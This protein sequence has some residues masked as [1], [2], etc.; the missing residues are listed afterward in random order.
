MPDIRVLATG[1]EFP[2]GPVAMPDG[3]VLLVEIRGQRLTRVWPDGRKEVV[4]K[5]PG[6]PNGAAIGP[7]G[8][9]Y[10]CEYSG[11]RIRKAREFLGLSQD[12]LARLADVS[13]GAVS[14][15]EAGRGMATPLL[16]FVKLNRVMPNVEPAWRAVVVGPMSR[17][18]QPGAGCAAA[19]VS[20][21]EALAR[22][23]G[24]GTKASEA[25]DRRAGARRQH[26]ARRPA[27]AGPP[28]RALRRRRQRP[29]ARGLRGPRGRQA[30]AAHGF[31]VRRGRERRHRYH[32][33]HHP[34]R[35]QRQPAG[36]GAGART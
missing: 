4:A 31:R 22:D 5:I 6:G 19:V 17:S 21:G 12:Q 9:L 26:R 29:H 27:R 20:A 35:R 18:H 16:T 33:R 34:D 8:A 28:A 25:R 32:R 24:A 36:A 3:S 13:Q 11:Q 10:F 2:E 7:D 23:R 14:R 1:L 15:V 30:T